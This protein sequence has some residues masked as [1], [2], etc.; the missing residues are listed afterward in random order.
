MIKRIAAL[1]LI[2]A[3]IG[4]SFVTSV[5]A[6]TVSVS[7]TDIPASLEEAFAA[8]DELFDSG[9]KEEIKNADRRTLYAAFNGWTVDGQTTHWWTGGGL[10]NQ[11]RHAWLWSESPLREELS[12]I[13]PYSSCNYN[14]WVGSTT[15]E[16]YRATSRYLGVASHCSWDMTMFIVTS[17]HYRLNGEEFTIEMYIEEL[18]TERAE[19][20]KHYVEMFVM[21]ISLLL[22]LV[23]VIVAVRIF[24][25]RLPR[26]ALT[27]ERFIR[28]RILR[29]TC[30]T[31][32]KLSRI[33][34][35]V[36]IYSLLVKQIEWLAMFVAER[37]SRGRESSIAYAWGY[38]YRSIFAPL[39]VVAV[40]LALIVSVFIM[41][42]FTDM[43]R[44]QVAVSAA[45]AV[46]LEIIFLRVLFPYLYFFETVFSD[47]HW[48]LGVTGY[49]FTPLHGRTYDVLYDAFW[50]VGF[51]ILLI[52]SA[53]CK[54]TAQET[55]LA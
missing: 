5:K 24:L 3:T 51:A 4:T 53:R 19:E 46:A 6:E 34:C 45:I 49:Y 39:A 17:Y 14:E 21:F 11:I 50:A 54:K 36:I 25:K 41:F 43:T 22:I 38:D 30:E 12:E 28:P 10:V 52:L 1:L 9:H 47:I 48:L 13:A 29:V 7:E 40:V 2:A 26:P 35:V 15:R 23:A 16:N 44:K 20:R 27:L 32:V 8:L 42:G 37:Q 31:I 18:K 55:H 33:S